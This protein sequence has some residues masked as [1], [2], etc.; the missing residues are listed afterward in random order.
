LAVEGVLDLAERLQHQ[1][2]LVGLHADAGIGDAN[3]NG[4][5]LGEPR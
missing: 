5:I 3:F 1:L 4:A 2:N